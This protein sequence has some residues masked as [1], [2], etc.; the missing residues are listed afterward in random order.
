MSGSRSR[1]GPGLGL[2]VWVVWWCVCGGQNYLG[3]SVLASPGTIQELTEA[4]FAL[5]EY[6]DTICQFVSGSTEDGK[7]REWT[8]VLIDKGKNNSIPIL[9]LHFYEKE[10]DPESVYHQIGH[11][12]HHSNQRFK[13]QVP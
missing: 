4:M 2:I 1:P 13:C 5:I 10:R 3:H 9:L 8:F 12:I 11:W 6:W 7:E